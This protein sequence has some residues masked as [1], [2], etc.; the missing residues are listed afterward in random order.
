MITKDDTQQQ[1]NYSSEAPI[2]PLYLL[3]PL[4]MRLLHYVVRT[5]LVLYESSALTHTHL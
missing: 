4:P 1:F 5:Y 3:F 2:F